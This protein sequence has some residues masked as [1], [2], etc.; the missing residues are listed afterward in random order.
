M[1]PL[2][3]ILLQ[4]LMIIVLLDAFDK[5]KKNQASIYFFKC[6]LGIV[7]LPILIIIPMFLNT[8]DISS[9][10]IHTDIG[11]SIVIII[12]GMSV[13]MCSYPCRKYMKYLNS[14]TVDRLPEK[15]KQIYPFKMFID[16]GASLWIIGAIWMLVGAGLLIYELYLILSK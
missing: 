7:L 2:L 14:E 11:Q 10:F 13:F 8:L 4:I 5:Y 6:I 12:M 1:F 3:C 9:D 15:D 16:R